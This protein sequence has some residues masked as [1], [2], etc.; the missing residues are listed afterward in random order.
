MEWRDQ[1]ILLSTRQH[2]ETSVIIDVLT[3]SL[4][5]HKGVVRGGKSRKIAPVLQ[6]GSQL[7]LIWRARLQEH[8]GTFQVELIRSRTAI[9]LSDRLA[10]TGL[11][12]VTAM[13]LAF[14]PDRESNKPLFNATEKL[15]DLLEHPEVWPSAY[16]RWEVGLL[17]N[18]GFGL[19]LSACAVTGQTHDLVFISPKTGRAVSRDGAG[20]WANQLLPL[21]PIMLGK[22]TRKCPDIMRALEVT[23]Y[24]FQNHACRVLGIR[25]MPLARSIFLD[26][27]K[28]HY[29]E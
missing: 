2:G 11:G 4:G 18:L 27:F 28:K 5:R 24:F 23:G 17:D 10:L 19:E 22:D 25:K 9:I 8:I 6:P 26:T 13:L 20:K 16:L 1:G 15:L 12:A 29:Y 3:S 21:L 7:D 14:L